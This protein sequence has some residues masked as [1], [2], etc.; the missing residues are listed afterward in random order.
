LQERIRYN[1]EVNAEKEILQKEI[2][3]ELDQTILP[4]VSRQ[5]TL[6]V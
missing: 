4:K 1:N 2:L 5:T 6:C 3:K